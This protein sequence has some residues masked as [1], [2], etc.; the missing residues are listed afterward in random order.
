MRNTA[1]CV[2]WLAEAAAA[3]PQRRRQTSWRSFIKLHWEVL[4]SIDFTTV[5]V[6]TSGG[7]PTYFSDFRGEHRLRGLP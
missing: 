1:P 2:N 3:A 6:W 7:L 4:A 5:E